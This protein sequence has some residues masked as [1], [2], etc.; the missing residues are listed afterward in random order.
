MGRTVE[1][2]WDDGTILAVEL[3]LRGA[4]HLYRTDERWRGPSELASIVIEV[5]A[6]TAVCFNAGSVETYR[7]FDPRR[8]PV[9][10]TPGPDFRRRGVDEGRAYERLRSLVDPEAMI[11]EALADERMLAGI[12]NVFRSEILFASRVSPFSAVVA[13]DDDTLRDL[14]AVAADQVSTHEAMASRLV[15]LRAPGGLAVY[16][17][18]GKQCVACGTV[19]RTERVGLRHRP[20][21]WCPN[22][23]SR[24]DRREHD[25]IGQA[26]STEVRRTAAAE[27]A[28]PKG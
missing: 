24:F 6:W 5:P 23:Q 7:A 16:G 20:V 28:R 18:A 8:H 13:I 22:C 12:T 1:V 27:H 17:R 4:W 15:D 11:C 25:R 3:R 14:I 21:F 2:T 10:G 26:W 19:I 9:T